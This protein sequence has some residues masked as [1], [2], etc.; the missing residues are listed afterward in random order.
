MKEIGMRL[1]DIYIRS[2]RRTEIRIL[3]FD[4][5]MEVVL[6]KLLTTLN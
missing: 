2:E 5:R 6:T 3:P 4:T 1:I